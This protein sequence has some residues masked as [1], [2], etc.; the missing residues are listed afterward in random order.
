MLADRE[1]RQIRKA[2]EGVL[3]LLNVYEAQRGVG[4]K[5]LNARPVR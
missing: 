2:C 4:Q 3:A 1:L 5:K